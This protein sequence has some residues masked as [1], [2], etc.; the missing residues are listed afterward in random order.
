MQV[1]TRLTLNALCDPACFQRLI[2]LTYEKLLS[3]FAFNCKL[4]HYS[5]GVRHAV[6]FDGLSI[7]QF[8]IASRLTLRLGM[9]CAVLGTW[10]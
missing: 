5:E 3:N 6:V 1:D 8:N 7:A 2:L 9:F 4:R 10:D